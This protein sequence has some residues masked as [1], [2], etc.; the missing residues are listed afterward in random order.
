MIVRPAAARPCGSAGQVMNVDFLRVFLQLQGLETRRRS[1]RE[2][3][4]AAPKKTAAETA[5]FHKEQAAYEEESARRAALQQNRA[6]LEERV[7]VLVQRLAR[8]KERMHDVRNNTEYQALLREMDHAERE[9]GDIDHKLADIARATDECDA[10][11]AGHQ[12]GFDAAKAAHEENLR[13]I[14]AETAGFQRELDGLESE[15]G[16]IAAGL[17]H[18]QFSLYEKLAASRHGVVVVPVQSGC[19]GG[20]HVKLRPALISQL[21]RGGAI[22]RCDSCA[23]ILYLPELL[24]VE[25]PARSA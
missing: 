10:A 4:A 13:Q 25:P 9:K 11:L 19:C 2:S 23:R 21:K 16:S 6:T 22:V 20:C 3:I 14:D 5:R 8:D 24:Q 12:G 15:R 7:Q 17:Q 1:L 18:E